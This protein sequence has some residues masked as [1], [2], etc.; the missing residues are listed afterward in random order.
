[1][2][3]SLDLYLSGK[4]KKDSRGFLRIRTKRSSSFMKLDQAASAA[5][6]EWRVLWQRLQRGSRSELV[7]WAYNESCSSAMSTREGKL[8]WHGPD[9]LRGCA[10]SAPT[11]APAKRLQRR[12]CARPEREEPMRRPPEVAPAP[13]I[14]STLRKPR[15]VVGGSGSP[16]ALQTSSAMPAWMLPPASTWRPDSRRRLQLG[17]ACAFRVSR[18][19]SGPRGRAKAFAVGDDVVFRKQSLRA[20]NA[21]GPAAPGSLRARSRRSATARR[22]GSRGTGG[23]LAGARRRSRGR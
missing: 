2:G 23:E 16:E 20:R 11:S 18:I 13:M 14:S 9:A 6:A 17:Y 10:S 1:M 21:W 7:V 12:Q 4:T 19:R 22:T 15:H 8:N 5:G 3:F